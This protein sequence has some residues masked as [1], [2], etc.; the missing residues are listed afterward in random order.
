MDIEDKI[1][2]LQNT[3]YRSTNGLRV[4]HKLC[5]FRLSPLQIIKRRW[6]S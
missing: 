2:I 3:G 1:Q 4:F 5:K 6:K